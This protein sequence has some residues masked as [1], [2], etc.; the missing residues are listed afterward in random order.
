MH[1]DTLKVIDFLENRFIEE[2]HSEAEQV[3]RLDPKFSISRTPRLLAP[4]KHDGDFE[5]FVEGFRAAG[6]PD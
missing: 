5:H 6:L 2:A 3:L 4:F 1:S